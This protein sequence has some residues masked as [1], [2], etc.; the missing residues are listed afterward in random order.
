VRSYVHC[1]FAGYEFAGFVKKFKLAAAAGDAESVFDDIPPDAQNLTKVGPV[2]AFIKCNKR[3][4]LLMINE[5]L[6][7]LES[8]VVVFTKP[9]RT[10]N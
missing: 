10:S 6:Q 2:P 7:A 8:G 9:S 1:W 5:G 4:V 3:N